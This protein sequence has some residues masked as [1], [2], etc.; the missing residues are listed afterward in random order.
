MKQIGRN[1]GSV[2]KGRGCGTA[3][4][5]LEGHWEAGPAP[6]EQKVQG[7]PESPKC[8]C[9]PEVTSSGAPFHPQKCPFSTPTSS[10]TFG[11]NGSS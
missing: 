5:G 8:V 1:K 9:C 6:S 7:R 4:E 2:K 11:R 10:V 3:P